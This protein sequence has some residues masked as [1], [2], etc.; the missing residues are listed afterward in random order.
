MQALCIPEYLEKVVLVLHPKSCINCSIHFRFFSYSLSSI[1]CLLV[2]ILALSSHVKGSITASVFVR[3]ESLLIGTPLFV[4]T[5]CLTSSSTAPSGSCDLA[6]VSSIWF[7]VLSYTVVVFL[8]IL[9]LSPNLSTFF[10]QN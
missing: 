6:G 5:D 8:Y 10:F 4:R 3:W 7:M 9:L 2:G 1:F